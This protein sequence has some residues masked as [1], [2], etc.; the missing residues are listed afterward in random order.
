MV[1]NSHKRYYCSK[2]L[3]KIYS[4]ETFV[5]NDQNAHIGGITLA[6]TIYSTSTKPK[7]YSGNIAASEFNVKG[8]NVFFE[9]EHDNNRGITVYVRDDLIVSNTVG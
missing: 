3:V 1:L 4:L 5:L 8:Y 7:T 9:G 2:R 6:A